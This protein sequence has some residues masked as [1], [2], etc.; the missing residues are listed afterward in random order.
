[1]CFLKNQRSKFNHALHPNSL[2][3]KFDFIH[4]PRNIENDA[5]SDTFA[6]LNGYP[7]S[8]N[9]SPFVIVRKDKKKRNKPYQYP[10]E[11]Y[12]SHYYPTETA[13]NTAV[14]NN[15]AGT[16]YLSNPYHQSLTPYTSVM[17]SQDTVP[18]SQQQQ[19]RPL[20]PHQNF[21]Y[22]RSNLLAPPPMTTVEPRSSFPVQTQNYQYHHHPSTFHWDRTGTNTINPFMS[23][24]SE[25]PIDYLQN[26]LH[27]QTRSNFMERMTNQK[28]EPRLLHYYTGRNYFASLDPSETMLTRHHSPTAGFTPGI[29]YGGNP[30]YHHQNDYTKSIM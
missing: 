19:R 14:T 28:Q 26:D 1:M 15:G 3:I 5:V 6:D 13:N 7:S 12:P 20:T 30:S 17:T 23:Y 25:P 11:L 2:Y 18:V 24:G 9:P 4:L 21:D 16:N 8:L 22:N 10:Q 27:Y 29:R